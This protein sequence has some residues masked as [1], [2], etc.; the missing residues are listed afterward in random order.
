MKQVIKKIIHSQEG[1]QFGVLCLCTLFSF[2][3]LGYRCCCIDF[4]WSILQSPSMIARYRGI[5]TFLFLVWNLFLAWIPYWIALLLPFL[6]R[7]SKLIFVVGL[8]F[9]LLFFPNAPYII[10]DLLHLRSRQPIPHWYDVMLIFSFAWTGWCLG[11]ASLFQI[12]QLVKR[13][14]HPI[15]VWSFIIISMGLAGL[16]IYIG[17]FQ[18]WNSWDIFTQPEAFWQEFFQTICYPTAEG[19]TIGMALVFGVFLV[20]GYLFLLS[21]RGKSSV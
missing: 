20:I 21:L 8:F 14:W 15:V 4:D 18:R 10:T 19:Y 5:P 11:M 16:G 12:H 7:Q 1:Q 6:Y 9:W 17:R 3:L 13:I 2:V